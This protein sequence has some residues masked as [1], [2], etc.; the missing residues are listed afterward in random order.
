METLVLR[1]SDLLHVGQV[2]VAIMTSGVIL[3][4]LSQSGKNAELT[5]YKSK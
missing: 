3:G 1:K 2:I 5:K 4:K